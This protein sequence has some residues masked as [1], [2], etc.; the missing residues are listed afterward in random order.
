MNQGY[1]FFISYHH[2]D[3]KMAEWIAGVL[4]TAGY[5][6]FIQAWDFKLCN[7]TVL[8]MQ[9]GAANAQITLALLSQYYLSSTFTQPEWVATL[10]SDSTGEK[11]R[12]IPV[13]IEDIN[14][15]GLL[16][17][18][19]CI[20]LVDKEEEEARTEILNGVQMEG[21]KPKSAPPFPGKIPKNNEIKQLPDHWYNSWLDKR[22]KELENGQFSTPLLKGAKLVLHLLPIES[23]TTNKQYQI[24]DLTQPLNLKPFYTTGW[25]DEVNKYGYYTV[26]QWSY[27]IFPHAYVQFFREGIIESIDMGMLQPLN[28]FKF[29]PSIKFEQDIIN[30]IKEKYL[31]AL[32]KLHVKLP[33]AI[34]I[35]LLDIK[36]Y[37]ISENYKFRRDVI[38]TSTLRLP[39]VVINSWEDHIEH[40]LKKSF[41]YLWNYCGY[42]GSLNYDENGN[43]R[44]CRVYEGTS[45][46]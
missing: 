9:H 27:A 42:E 32:K 13:R 40:I 28:E 4:E 2:H 34:S 37:Y 3:E 21:F 20:D 6:T 11:R 15:D 7:N 19:V 26:A 5:R 38:D 39:V 33:V 35:S 46:C 14:L 43:W 23:V 25:D 30:Y 29:I 24:N 17:Q 1:D 31:H 36:D 44:P 8:Q 22:I 10:D 16:P 18:G 12:F 41:D 45:N